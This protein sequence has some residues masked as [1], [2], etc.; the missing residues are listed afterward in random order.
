[1]TGM[2]VALRRRSYVERKVV[3]LLR[4]AEGRA[5]SPARAGALSVVPTAAQLRAFAELRKLGERNGLVM[6]PVGSL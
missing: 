2:S 4:G 1:M 5:I 6:R 3:T